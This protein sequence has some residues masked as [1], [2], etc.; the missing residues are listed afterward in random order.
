MAA[1]QI[2][3]V[4]H[5]TS[6]TNTPSSAD[7]TTAH[8]LPGE[9]GFAIAPGVTKLWVGDDTSNRLLLSTNPADNPLISFAG[10]IVVGNTEPAIKTPGL[11]WFD[12]VTSQTFIWTGVEWVVA[13]NPG[14]GPRGPLPP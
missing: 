14:A 12:T 8:L 3:Q 6:A 5:T 7:G 4:R 2:I 11:G 13:V 10:G 9:P 1:S